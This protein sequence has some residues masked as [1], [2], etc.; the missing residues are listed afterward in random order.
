MATVLIDDV[1]S[2]GWTT[3]FPA[4]SWVGPGREEPLV[5]KFELLAPQVSGQSA[6]ADV[7]IDGSDWSA[8][9]IGRKAFSS[10][11]AGPGLRRNRP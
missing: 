11:T 7:W 8:L 3:S 10:E 1:S 4:G 2:D 9:A 5:L 6:W